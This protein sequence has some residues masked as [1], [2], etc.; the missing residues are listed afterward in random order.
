MTNKDTFLSPELPLWLS[1]RKCN[2]ALRMQDFQIRI[3]AEFEF[4]LRFPIFNP[5]NE[6]N[7]IKPPALTNEY[8]VNLPETFFI[9]PFPACPYGCLSVYLLQII[10]KTLTHPMQRFGVE[11][12][13]IDK[14]R[15]SKILKT[16]Y[17]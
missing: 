1:V 12:H 4:A 2:K 7:G 16:N 14:D 10:S 11:I 5:E 6:I 8:A 9:A 3:S 17:V 15:I 13:H